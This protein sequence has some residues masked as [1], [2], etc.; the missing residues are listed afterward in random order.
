MIGS[1]CGDEPTLISTSIDI[2]VN[3]VIDEYNA[4][5]EKEKRVVLERARRRE[6]FQLEFAAHREA[7]AKG[8]NMPVAES[9]FGAT[10]CRQLLQ[11]LA[12]LP[13]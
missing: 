1:D 5:R 11:D 3:E 12:D 7:I 9:W 13:Y 10:D 6:P 8:G 2:F 4:K